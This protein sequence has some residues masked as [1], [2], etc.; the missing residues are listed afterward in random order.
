MPDYSDEEIDKISDDISESEDLSEGKQRK[1]KHLSDMDYNGQND[2][3][4]RHRTGT[5]FGHDNPAFI[6]DTNANAK[7]EKSN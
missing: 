7:G 6:D 5:K 1:L 4:L 2:C 3:F